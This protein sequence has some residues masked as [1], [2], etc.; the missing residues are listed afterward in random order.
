MKH[1][2]SPDE[3]VDRIVDMALRMAGDYGAGG[4]GGGAYRGDG[5]VKAR[6]KK[7]SRQVEKG[8]SMEKYVTSENRR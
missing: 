8:S 1:Q 2:S 5:A 4:N 6:T 7:N 3:N